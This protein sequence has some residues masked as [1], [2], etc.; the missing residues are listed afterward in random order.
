LQELARIAAFTQGL[1]GSDARHHWTQVS[2]TVSDITIM[3]PSLTL[4]SSRRRQPGFGA[5]TTTT[6]AAPSTQRVEVCPPS[7]RCA[8]EATSAWQ[9]VLFW[10]MAPAPHD[11]APPV[12]RLPNVRTDFLATLAD[13]ESAD[14]DLVRS[15]IDQTHSLRELWHLRAEVFRVVGLAFSQTEAV[16]RV[17]LLNRHFPTRAPRSQY[18]PL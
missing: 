8:P 12:N 2:P 11:A 16:Q 3:L 13:I 10:L 18:A 7:L 15:R 4:L 14:A 1:R 17:A 9:R 6:M 5:R